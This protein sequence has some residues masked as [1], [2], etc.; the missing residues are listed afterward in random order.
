MSSAIATVDVVRAHHR[1]RELLGKIVQLVRRLRTTEH[2]EA[3]RS[4]ALF[5][6]PKAGRGAV[7]SLTP[8]GRT[9]L[10]PFPNHGLG[11]PG[12]H[13]VLHISLPVFHTLLNP[14]SAVAL[15][16]ESSIRNLKL[17]CLDSRI[18]NLESG[19]ALS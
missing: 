1:P 15:L 6:A 5:D 14:K 13:R 9:E 3:L 18:L 12:I 10:L 19:I 8:T 2:P 4:V 17:L 7:K 11:E 16:L